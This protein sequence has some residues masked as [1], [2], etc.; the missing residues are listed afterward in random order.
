LTKNFTLLRLVI[1]RLSCLL[2]KVAR[3]KEGGGFGF[4]IDVS[5]QNAF[6]WSLFTV[7]YGWRA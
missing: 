4:A 3:E 7:D 2:L 5:T 6:G 1:L